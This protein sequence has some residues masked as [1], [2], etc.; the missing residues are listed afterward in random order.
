MDLCE[1][2]CTANTASK[3]KH[4]V[5]STISL[6]LVAFWS[7]CKNKDSLP[8]YRYAIVQCLGDAV[9]VPAGAP[10]QVRNLH[11]CIK[12]AEDFVSPEN[13][14]HCFHLTQEFRALSDT[15]TNHEDKLQIKNI[16]YHAVKDSL[17]VLSNVKEET[18]A[19]LKSNNEIKKEET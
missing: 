6:S 1:N 15:H 7:I 11:N 14:S 3:G 17:A 10:H 9:F 2:G 18:L 13:V 12:V 5:H 4:C 16:I 8:C 19:K